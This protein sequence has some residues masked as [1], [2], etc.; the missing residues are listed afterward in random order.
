V[1]PLRQPEYSLMPRRLPPTVRVVDGLTEAIDEVVAATGFS[2]VVRVDVGG[3]VAVERAYG[4]AHRGHGIPNNVE[5]RFGIASGTKGLTA[6]TVVSLIEDGRL[7]LA[8]TARSLLGDDLPLIDDGVTVEHLLA[9]RSGIG[10]Y[11]DEEADLDITDYVLTVPVHELATTE[12]Y[13]PALD[14]FAS[15]FPPGERFAYCNGG[16][17]V[18]AL[19]AE[20]ASGTS[21]HELVEQRVC[22]PAGMSVTAF[23][24][25]DELPGDAA[26]GYLTADAPRTNVFH[27]PVRGSGDGGVYST[28]ADV[29][30]LWT[31]FFAG[32]I[33]SPRWLDEMVRPHSAAPSEGMRYGLGF[34]LGA[35]N[36]V[37]I[38]VGGDAGVSFRTVADPSGQWAHTVLSNTSSGAW[39]VT[40]RLDELL[41]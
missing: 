5:T 23:L 37:V 3:T 33:V 40:R 26:T 35:S 34:W 7:E 8:T 38:L 17:V 14:G 22:R 41:G 25:S 10:D 9:H 29:H 12:Q 1:G 18:L 30:A 36:D 19:L 32:R 15:K 16:Y 4:M 6:L 20:R 28:A 27:L 13:L 11:V 24:R 21:F 2:G 39:P 31:A